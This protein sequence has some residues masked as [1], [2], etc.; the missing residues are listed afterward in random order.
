ME[1]FKELVHL[2][3]HKCDDPH[4][5]GAIRLN[6]ILWFSDV[7]AYLSTGAS[8]TGTQYVRR[9]RGPV[10]AHILKTLKELEA[11]DR[12]SIIEPSAPYEPREYHS[13]QDAD[14]SMFSEIEMGVVNHLT[15]D[16]C[17][18]HSAN[19]ISEL[20][21]DDIWK[22]AE[23]GEEIPLEA[24]L[25]N[26]RGDFRSQVQEWASEVVNKLES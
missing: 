26:Q 15:K 3:I 18:N 19:S 13:L 9:D 8:I 7:A 4:K 12:I 5:L 23:E 11:E 2:V 14:E 25:V 21:H 6:K 20:T 10:P 24:M 1:K 17:E 16:I 22:A